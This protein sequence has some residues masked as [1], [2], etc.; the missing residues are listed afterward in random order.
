MVFKSD[1]LKESKSAWMEVYSF[2]LLL[3]ALI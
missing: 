3:R 1:C 2:S